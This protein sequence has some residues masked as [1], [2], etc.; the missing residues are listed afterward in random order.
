MNIYWPFIWL[1]K[2]DSKQA[3]PLLYF[4]QHTPQKGTNLKQAKEC[5][6]IRLLWIRWPNPTQLL[7]KI[8]KSYMYSSPQVW[9][10]RRNLPQLPAASNRY[11]WT[12]SLSPRVRL[13]VCPVVRRP[14]PLSQH[15]FWAALAIFS[16]FFTQ[17]IFNKQ[18]T[19][20][21]S[22]CFNVILSAF[23]MLVIF[24]PSSAPVHFSL[25]A[26]SS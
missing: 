13:S 11:I 5:S 9:W 22:R 4:L 15:N 21:I 18:L 3:G 12:F 10:P 25:L 7:K 23:L 2:T 1:S 20:G 26:T 6:W 8:R 24:L 14:P 19:K 17:K 16:H